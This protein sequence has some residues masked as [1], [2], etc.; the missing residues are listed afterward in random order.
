M[1]CA[2]IGSP[3][4]LVAAMAVLPEGTAYAL[5]LLN[6]HQSC[7]RHEYI[8]FNEQYRVEEM[9]SEASSDGEDGSETAGEV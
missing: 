9:G 6:A 8:K 2:N 4:E 3:K 1:T 7:R 5:R